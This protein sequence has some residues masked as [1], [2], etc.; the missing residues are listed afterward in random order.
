[1][2]DLAAEEHTIAEESVILK[3]KAAG[4]VVN[5]KFLPLKSNSIS[6]SILKKKK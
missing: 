6:H 4:E 1:M 2:G 5:S 3:Y